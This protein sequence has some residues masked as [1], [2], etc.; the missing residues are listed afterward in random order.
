MSSIRCALRPGALIFVVVLLLP[1]CVTSGAK[2]YNLRE[3]H[4][5]D[6][7][8]KRSA[9][10]MNEMTFAFQQI[11]AAIFKGTK[12]ALAAPKPQKVEDPLEECVDNL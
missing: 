2:T 9:P 12:L 7:H 5:D 8:H 11:K 6:G 3:L 1:A 10:L 4:E